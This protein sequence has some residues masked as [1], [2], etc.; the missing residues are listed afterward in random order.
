[1]F[2]NTRISSRITFDHVTIETQLH[3]STW[4][5]IFIIYETI[6][7]SAVRSLFFISKMNE[8]FYFVPKMHCTEKI[9]GNKV[10]NAERSKR[11]KP[12]VKMSRIDYVCQRIKLKHYAPT[13]RK[14]FKGKETYLGTI[15]LR[16][17]NHF[18]SWIVH[19]SVTPYHSFQCYCLLVSLYLCNFWNN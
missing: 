15:Y 17:V 14:L 18:N 13:I 1:M 10:E 19:K 4:D 3:I 2:Q 7:R 5:F 12:L 11:S 16:L 8:V 9:Q 6:R